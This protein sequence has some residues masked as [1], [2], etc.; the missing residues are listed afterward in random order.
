MGSG[1]L[2]TAKDGHFWFLKSGAFLTK[3]V[4]DCHVATRRK[5]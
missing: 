3:E 4:A 5:L 2:P 1:S